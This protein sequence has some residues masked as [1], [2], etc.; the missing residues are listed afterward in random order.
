MPRTCTLAAERARDLRREQPDRARPDDEHLVAGRDRRRIEQDWQTHASGS[1]SAAAGRSSPSG[2]PVQLRA[3]T[4]TRG[5][6]APSTREPIERRSGHR[7]GRP[8]RHHSHAPHVEKYV[9]ET[10]RA[11]THSPVTPVPELRDDADTSWPIVT[12]GTER[13]SSSTMCRSVP[14]IPGRLDREHDVAPAR[15]PARARSASPTFPGPAASFVEPASSPGSTRAR[16][17]RRARG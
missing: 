4:T 9:S 5:A 14:Q 15:A 6:N 7:F 2:T 8:A 17:A 16:R 11:P 13:N 12:G 10:T 1:R 3:G